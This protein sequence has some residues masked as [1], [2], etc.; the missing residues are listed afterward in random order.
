MEYAGMTRRDEIKVRQQSTCKRC[1]GG[2][3]YSGALGAWVHVDTHI[4]P[5]APT[6][7]KE[8]RE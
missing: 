2:I 4:G 8:A 5:C 7:P 6:Q 1:G 3:Y